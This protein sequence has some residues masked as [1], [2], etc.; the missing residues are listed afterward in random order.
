MDK[1]SILQYQVFIATVD[2]GGE[3]KTNKKKNPPNTGLRTVIMP[4]RAVHS[5]NL[6]LG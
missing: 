6:G 3:L 1:A 5:R 2:R 4:D